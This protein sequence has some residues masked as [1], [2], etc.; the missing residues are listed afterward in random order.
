MT[1]KLITKNPKLA[2]NLSKALKDSMGKYLDLDMN[3]VAKEFLSQKRAEEQIELLIKEI[4]KKEDF[5]IKGKK[6][7]EIGSGVGTLLI[8]ARNKFEIDAI[9]IEPSEGEFS[10][11]K[12]ISNELISENNLSNNIIIDS[13]AENLPFENSSFDIVFSSNVIEHVKDPKKVIN[14]SLRVLKSGGYL[15]FVIPNYFSFW[16]GHYGILWPC[17]INK[18]IA[19]FFVKI[20][21]KN[22]DYI[23]TLQ[24]ITPF[25]INKI[26]KEKKD[27]IE[28]I[29]WGKDVFK[30]RLISGNYSDWATLKKIRFVVLMIQ[31]L[32][33]AHLVSNILN[34]FQMYTPL[35]IT[36]RKK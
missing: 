31:K 29:G 32:K 30:N 18:T 23:D 4:N 13:T 14:E 7:L 17:L 34:T 28:I 27:Y 22:P 16:E 21:G 26:L 5:D 35:I 33:I 9:G 2:E 11:F 3:I 15:H 20:L 36:V 12:K 19:K 24:L 25:Y 10:P 6:F 8:T 1:S